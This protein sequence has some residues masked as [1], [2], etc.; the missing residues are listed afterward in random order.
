[1]KRIDD[2][3]RIYDIHEA[4]EIESLPLSEDEKARILEKTLV[5]AGIREK[6]TEY[7][8]SES[9]GIREKMAQY[10]GSEPERS[11]ALLPR[12]RFRSL[13]LAG[14]LVMAMFTI[15]FAAYYYQLDEKFLSYLGTRGDEQT[16]VLNSSG[17]PIH[18][19]VTNN[20]LTIDVKEIIGDQ[21]SFYVLF[22]VIAPEG[23]ILNR[24]QYRFDLERLFVEGANSMGWSFDQLPDG[25]TKDNKISLVLSANV[26]EDLIGKPASLTFENFTT[27]HW[28][29]ET[30]DGTWL[31]LVDGQWKVDFTLDYKDLSQTITVGK[32]VDIFKG[33]ST[34]ESISISPLSAT[35]S[36]KGKSVREFDRTPPPLSSEGDLSDDL[37]QDD[38]TIGMKDGRTISK[39]RSTGCSVENDA[40]TKTYNFQE[41]LDISQIDWIEF[42][43]V[44][45]QFE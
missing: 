40:M 43:G 1:M 42:R 16:K 35:V 19:Q 18:K 22:D 11:R 23:M 30:Q 6:M 20:G 15:S 32:D 34:F 3:L 13:L 41:I 33:K 27:Y 29:E 36:V 5:K 9:D 38:L 26:N 2:M 12:R 21:Y 4:V 45:V 24:E 31:P 25:N 10:A 44:K 8:E 39:T 7:A 37:S 14:I 17:V 28:D